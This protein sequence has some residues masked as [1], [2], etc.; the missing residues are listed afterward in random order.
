MKRLIMMWLTARFE[1]VGAAG[2]VERADV[3]A[4]ARR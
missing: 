1:M 2:V 3:P 4:F